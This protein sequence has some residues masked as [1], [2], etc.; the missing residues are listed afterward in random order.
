MNN[1]C[2]VVGFQLSDGTNLTIDE[3][4]EMKDKNIEVS[5]TSRNPYQ[6]MFSKVN[7]DLVFVSSL[8]NKLKTTNLTVRLN[9]TLVGNVPAVSILVGCS[10]YE[11]LLIPVGETEMAT[12]E[13]RFKGNGEVYIKDTTIIDIFSF[14]ELFDKYKVKGK[15]RMK[16]AGRL[17]SELDEW[18]NLA[19]KTIESRWFDYIAEE[20][21][22]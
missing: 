19:S 4:K 21:E 11:M 15:I 9:K 10:D 18:I 17:Q 20:S 16:Y 8:M 3:Y 22:N 5:E 12:T 14:I 13:I 2:R 1:G 6:I 7:A